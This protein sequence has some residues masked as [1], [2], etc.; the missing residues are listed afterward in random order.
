VQRTT[1][2]LH[3]GHTAQA[4]A[5]MQLR[6]VQRTTLELHHKH[7][8]QACAAMQ[9][10]HVLRTT[11]ELHFNTLKKVVKQQLKPV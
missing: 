7:T 3:H 1:L 8:A 5:A 10:R 6:H 2:E 9:L 11:L 4:C